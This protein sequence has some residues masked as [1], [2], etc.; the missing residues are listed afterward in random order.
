MYVI[1]TSKPGQFRTE[2]VAGVRPVE[3]YDYLF[4]ER[5]KA[6]F[7]IAAL[8]QETKIRVID[9]AEPPVL[10]LVPTKFLGR[11]ESLEAA[12]RE[13][14]HL[15]AFGSVRAALRPVPVAAGA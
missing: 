15:T 2:P 12:R 1:L 7:V 6:R 13:L 11:Y 14:E 5:P 3:A 8:E 9:E 4:G 10:N